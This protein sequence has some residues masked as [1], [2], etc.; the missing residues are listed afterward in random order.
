MYQ[1]MV[2]NVRVYLYLNTHLFLTSF[3]SL[4]QC[5]LAALQAQAHA[6]TQ[7][8]ASAIDGSLQNLIN[9]TLAAISGHSGRFLGMDMETGRWRLMN[10]IFYQLKVEETFFSCLQVKRRREQQLLAEEMVMRELLEKRL[11]AQAEYERM[12]RMQIESDYRLKKRPPGG[13]IHV[14]SAG[15]PPP[16]L[17]RV[18]L[19][20]LQAQAL[21]ELKRK[22]GGDAVTPNANPNAQNMTSL[23]SEF[24]NRSEESKQILE[25][26]NAVQRDMPARL[27]NSAVAAAGPEFP[28]V[29]AGGS[30]GPVLQASGARVDPL[31][32]CLGGML[33]MKQ[34]Q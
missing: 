11:S 23:L 24:K 10:A 16:T 18:D 4:E 29:H 1:D 33:L 28:S 7:A 31:M 32:E 9:E 30:K 22:G 5:Y 15:Q 19:M 25:Q 21:S 14:C 3:S 27:H 13:A 34:S 17:E 26:L 2:D 20:A 6:E 8:V 12:Q